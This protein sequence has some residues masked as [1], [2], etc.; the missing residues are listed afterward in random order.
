M[1]FKLSEITPGRIV[2]A[3]SRRVK[4]LPNAMAWQS[5]SDM[6]DKIR[7]FHNIHK[8]QRCF[9]IANGPSLKHTNLS[10]LKDEYSIGMNRIYLLFN[11]TFKT[12]YHAVINELV[13]EQFR[14]ELAELECTKFIDWKKR[15]L[16]K[17][18][19]MNMLYISQ[20]LDDGFSADLSEKVYSGGTVTYVCLQLAYYMGFSEV[21]LIGLDHSFKDKGTPNKTEVRSGDDDNHFH[22]NY[23]PKGVK[24]Q[25]PDL[26]RSELAYEKARKAFEKDNRKIIDATIG[27]HCTVFEKADY[28]SLFSK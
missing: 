3:I 16:F 12:T 4:G 27:G 18:T 17:G 20:A 25:L 21:V 10:L 7:S 2:E 23:F 26:L 1:R 9:V 11:E 5:A 8:G 22:P 6:K 24:W 19:D 13:I 15:D 14:D 28:N